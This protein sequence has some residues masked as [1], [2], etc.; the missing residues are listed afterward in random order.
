M[1][2][3]HYG[4]FLFL[5]SEGWQEPNIYTVYDRI[6]CDF[7]A[8][9]TV[10]TPYIYMALNNPIYIGTEGLAPHP[11]RPCMI[12]SKCTVTVADMLGLKKQ[13]SEICVCPDRHLTRQCQLS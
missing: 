7:P 9:N 5:Y 10:Y 6:F 11:P 4:T 3:W 12:S 8:R 2:G 1:A 13:P